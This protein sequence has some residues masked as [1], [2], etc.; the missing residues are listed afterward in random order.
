MDYSINVCWKETLQYFMPL[1]VIHTQG[2]ANTKLLLSSLSWRLNS[3]CIGGTLKSVKV[4]FFLF[5]LP[6]RGQKIETKNPGAAESNSLAR[7]PEEMN[8]RMEDCF[9]FLRGLAS[10]LP[11][12]PP[13]RI[14]VWVGLLAVSGEGVCWAHWAHQKNRSKSFCN[15]FISL[16][17]VNFRVGGLPV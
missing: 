12:P 8:R 4:F 9:P 2:S 14:S 10:H 5:F 11:P 7:G 3:F 16:S 6:Q 15:G 1:P 13:C 17:S